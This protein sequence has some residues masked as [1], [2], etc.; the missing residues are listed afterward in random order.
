LPGD[1]V[2]LLIYPPELSLTGTVMEAGTIVA[3]FAIFPG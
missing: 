2:P 3:L 1:P